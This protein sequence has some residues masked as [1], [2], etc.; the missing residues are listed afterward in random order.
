M[1][2]SRGSYGVDAP[3]VPAIFVLVAVVAAVL[4]LLGGGWV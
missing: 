3:Y 4:A 1:T 2:R